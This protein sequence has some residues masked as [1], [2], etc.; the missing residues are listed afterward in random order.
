MFRRLYVS[1]FALLSVFGW[2]ND[3]I[4]APTV[5]AGSIKTSTNIATKTSTNS[6]KTSSV[7]TNNTQT[8]NADGDRIGSV[9]I[10]TKPSVSSGS[11]QKQDF[12]EITERIDQI[13]RELTALINAKTDSAETTEL[14][15]KIAEL[16]NDLDDSI[17]DLTDLS[18]QLETKANKDEIPEVNI[19]AEKVNSAI[20]DSLAFRQLVNSVVNDNAQIIALNTTIANKADRAEIQSKADKSDVTALENALSNSIE[21]TVDRK[22]M[23]YYTKSD[24]D[25]KIAQA[26]LS[27]GNVD[28]SGYAKTADIARD[29]ATKTDLASIPTGTD[30]TRVNSLIETKLA[31]KDYATNSSVETA[32]Q[33]AQI[34]GSDIDLTGYAKTADIARD[35]ATKTELAGISTGTDEATVN[36]LIDEKLVGYATTQYVDENTPT[37]NDETVMAALRNAEGL[38][39]I[40][41]AAVGDQLAT[42]A[43]QTAFE[44]LE[45][46]VGT[47]ID[48]SALNGYALSS[49]IKDITTLA[50]DDASQTESMTIDENKNSVY[51]FGYNPTTKRSGWI[52]TDISTDKLGNN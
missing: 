18:E 20:S 36:N 34:A 37:V 31:G 42:K 33:N 51:L 47:K 15:D 49:D 2:V 13:Q 3:A 6:E 22:L 43:N 10:W 29:Y 27:G 9:R 17:G 5:R 23:P 32:I 4:S 12:S 45:E 40:V 21:N 25:T 52:K 7:A 50:N 24:I 11:S 14:R 39:D 38:Q 44:E 41:L 28:L 8:T 35:Y 48:S 19:T 30:E 1:I 46:T 16:Q 26:Q